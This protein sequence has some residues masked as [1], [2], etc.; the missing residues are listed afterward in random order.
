MNWRRTVTITSLCLIVLAAVLL[1]LGQLL[2]VAYLAGA[3][4]ILA[5]LM[6]VIA[7]RGLTTERECD[8][9][10]AQIGNEALVTVTVRNHK[11]LPVSWAVVEDLLPGEVQVTDGVPARAT[12]IRAFGDISLKYTIKCTQRGYFRIGPVMMES[13]DFF[14]MMRRYVASDIAHFL[15]VYPQVVPLQ[16]YSIPTQR[17]LGEL[18]VRQR[19]LEDPTR[20]AGVREYRHGDPLRIVH[21]KATAKTGRLHSKL[22]DPATL[23]GAHIILDFSL[24]AWGGEPR[25]DRSELAVTAAASIAAHV[26]ARHQQIGLTSNGID[27]AEVW[28]ANP[29]RV[30][31]RS[32]SQ[33]R[34]LSEQ[35]HI[36]EKLTP[37]S[38]PVQ[39]GTERAGLLMET[40][41]RLELSQGLDC[42]QMVTE[43]YEKWPREV[44]TIFIVP[45]VPKQLMEQLVGLRA[46]GFP[47][48]VI[49]VDNPES[50]QSV[51]PVLSAAGINVKHLSAIEDLYDL[52]L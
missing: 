26:A 38:V 45:D 36:P 24:P 34:S 29:V 12:G 27:A 32:R 4:A 31:A 42:A 23:I 14:G 49:V 9:R 2:F 35:R 51:S 1:G 44:M 15:T 22:F 13:G 50:W 20:I 40:L 33:A 18:V 5:L 19:L 30:I 25:S 21:W 48:L 41:A 46:N 8:R 7:P 39:R 16:R 37:V 10:H 28:E 6:T 43:E 17:P 3:V 52:S 11:P 47:L